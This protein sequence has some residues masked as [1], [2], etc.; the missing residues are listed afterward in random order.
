MTGNAMERIQMRGR[1]G[2]LYFCEA[3]L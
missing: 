1:R 2:D 3:L